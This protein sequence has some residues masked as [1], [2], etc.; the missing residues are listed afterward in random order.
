MI[1]DKWK[2]FAIARNATWYSLD[3]KAVKDWY[4]SIAQVQ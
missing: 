1:L 3:I 2:D 4:H